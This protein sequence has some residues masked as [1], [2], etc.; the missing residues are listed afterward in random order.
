MRSRN[1]RADVATLNSRPG[2]H[3]AGRTGCQ[4]IDLFVG[5]FAFSLQPQANQLEGNALPP[6]ISRYVDHQVAVDACAQLREEKLEMTMAMN[7]H[8]DSSFA[9]QEIVLLDELIEENQVPRLHAHRDLFEL[10]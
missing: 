3:L 9:E 4:A 10:R 7:T 1:K 5:H 6:Q 8:I 2:A